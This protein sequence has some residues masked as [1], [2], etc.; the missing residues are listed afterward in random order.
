MTDVVAAGHLV[1][2]LLARDA[3]LWPEGSEA[4]FRLGWLDSPARLGPASAEVAAWASSLEFERVVLLGMGGS[5]L[6]PEVLRAAIDTDRLFVCDTTDPATVASVPVDGSFFLLSSKSG[7]TLEPR[8]L[9]SHF[10]SK[11]PDG[12]RWAAICDPGTRPIEL[13]RVHDF[14]RVFENDPNIGGR[15]SVLS[16]FGLVPAAL[17]GL[18]PAELCRR[19]QAIDVAEAVA[20]GASWAEAHR[21]GRDKL[22]IHMADGPFRAFGLWAEQLVAES[23]GKQGTGIVP[24]PTGDAEEGPDREHVEVRLGDVYDLGGEFLRWEIATAIAGSLLG[25]DA[26]DQPDVEAAKVATAAA[27]EH[28][29]L[30]A[31]LPAGVEVAKHDGLLAWLKARVGPGDYVALQAYVPYGQDDALEG[32][33]CQVRDG[34]GGIAVTAGY[35]PRFLHSTGQLHKGGPGSCVAVQIVPSSPTADLAV[36]DHDY[37][38]GT[39]V[40][41]QALGDLHALR[42]AGRRVVRVEVTGGDLQGIS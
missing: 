17:L 13:A 16:W 30:P 1:E 11:V 7:G 37:D 36:P 14:A 2:R 41:A 35:G 23:L 9:F 24:V 38:F 31:E 33:R 3:S 20:L 18:D 10:W 5:S 4:P 12:S 28:L 25:V 22:T 29:P 32:L 27:L 15:Y 8:A 26:F 6:G 19:A 34:L 40:A 42:A 39:L 21:A